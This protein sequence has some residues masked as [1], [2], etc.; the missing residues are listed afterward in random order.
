MYGYSTWSSYVSLWACG[1]KNVEFWLA[2][3]KTRPNLIF[4]IFM[5]IYANPLTPSLPSSLHECATL[6]IAFVCFSLLSGGLVSMLNG[7]IVLTSYYTCLSFFIINL[8]PKIMFCSKNVKVE[9]LLV[10]EDHRL[11]WRHQKL[12]LSLILTQ[13]IP[14][15]GIWRG[16]LIHME[17]YWARG[18]GE[19]LHSFSMNYRKMLLGHWRQ[20]TWGHFF[21]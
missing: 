10:Q 19:I 17:K 7:E 6:A 11:T 4:N 18:L 9:G 21:L 16:T 1:V 5:K 12:C 15:L 2:H 13:F 20:Q 14:E 3:K 8:S